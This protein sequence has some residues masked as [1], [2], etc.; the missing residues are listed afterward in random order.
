M[1][2]EQ[3]KQA[4]GINV[5][6]FRWYE[7][8]PDENPLSRADITDSIERQRYTCLSN[9][10]CSVPFMRFNSNW[11][12]WDERS[13]RCEMIF[14]DMKNT[15]V[16]YDRIAK[17]SRRYRKKIKMAFR[18]SDR[19]VM[20]Q[21]EAFNRHAGRPGVIRIHARIGGFNWGYYD[22]PEIAKQPWFIE[23]VDDSFDDTYCD[24]YARISPEILEKI[25]KNQSVSEEM[26]D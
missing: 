13:R 10:F 26:A 22:G 7:W 15:R 17:L 11:S 21:I 2:F 1:H 8:M 18:W 6:R 24:I 4:T 23:K 14:L 12:I 5:P 9:M 19:R 3:I 25:K 16:R 20:A